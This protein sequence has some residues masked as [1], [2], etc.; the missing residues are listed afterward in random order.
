MH[1]Y[2]FLFQLQTKLNKVHIVKANLGQLINLIFRIGDTS[3]SDR[4][5]GFA[6]RQVRWVVNLGYP[7]LASPFPER[8]PRGRSVS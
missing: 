4:K 3:I 5:R 2:L 1:L 7:V 6:F 8:Y